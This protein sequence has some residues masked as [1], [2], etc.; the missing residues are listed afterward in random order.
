M[1]AKKVTI[2]IPAGYQVPEGTQDGQTFD[3]SV[4]FK[5]E[6]DKLCVYAINGAVLP[7]F[8]DEKE[9]GQKSGTDDGL[10]ARYAAAMSAQQP[11]A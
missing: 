3:E 9:Q 5:L 2:P 10:Q 1:A 7:A 6:G 4:T 11:A 8:E